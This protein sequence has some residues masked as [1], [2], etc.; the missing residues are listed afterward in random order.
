MYKAR[1]KY[2]LPRNSE[3]S[4]YTDAV[5]FGCMRGALETTKKKD[6]KFQAHGTKF[7]HKSKK[8]VLLQ[9]TCYA[10]KFKGEQKRQRKTH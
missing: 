3:Q 1:E 4:K 7:V 10:V 6:K 9:R 5:F 8:D 2:K